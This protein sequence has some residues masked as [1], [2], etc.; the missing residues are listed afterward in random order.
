MFNIKTLAK[1]IRP[2]FEFL[3]MDGALLVGLFLLITWAVVMLQQRVSFQ[4]AQGSLMGSSSWRS[5]FV[6]SIGGC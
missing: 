4:S 3:L 6:A 1:G 5:A 2:F